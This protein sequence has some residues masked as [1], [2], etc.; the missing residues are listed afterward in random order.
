MSEQ[1][2]HTPELWQQ[3]KD[4]PHLVID[5]DENWVAWCMAS[6]PGKEGEDVERACLIAAAPDLLAA[7]KGLMNWEVPNKT[8]IEQAQAAI[9]KATGDSTPCESS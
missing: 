6:R 4:R 8:A 2:Q 3:D 5:A 1:Q 7:I 9:A